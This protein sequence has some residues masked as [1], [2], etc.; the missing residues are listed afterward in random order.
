MQPAG[1]EH[2]TRPAVG[3][4][5]PPPAFVVVPFTLVDHL[6]EPPHGRVGVAGLVEDPLPRVLVAHPVRALGVP[7]RPDQ[8]R[9]ALWRAGRQRDEQLVLVGP[10]PPAERR[11]VVCCVP[12]PGAA[13]VQRD[14]G[15]RVPEVL[16]PVTAQRAGDWLD[17]LT[18]QEAAVIAVPA[19]GQRG[20]ALAV[21]FRDRADHSDVLGQFAQPLLCGRLVRRADLLHRQHVGVQCPDRAHDEL[22]AL[23]LERRVVL[24]QVQRVVRREQHGIRG[25]P[26]HGQGS[27]SV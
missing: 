2:I 8:R 23:A 18:P 5:P 1:P 19:H 17:A 14:A 26:Q 15:Q 3:P 24:E 9:H 25:R 7:V 27:S 12:H 21:G 16:R 13:D 10:Q 4:V 22:V 6:V 20:P 11:G